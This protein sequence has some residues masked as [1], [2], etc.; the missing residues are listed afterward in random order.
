M[1]PIQ[2]PKAPAAIGPYSQAID[3]GAG[4][5]FVSGQLPIDPA[6]GAFPEGGVKAQTR[7][8]LLNAKAILEAAGLGLGNVVKTTVF[9]ADMADFAAMNEVYAE[10][11]SAPFPARSAVAMKTLPKGALVEIECIAA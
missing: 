5:V 1:T 8:S 4:I 10:F 7:Q 11:F 6:T 9:L 3:S 2:T